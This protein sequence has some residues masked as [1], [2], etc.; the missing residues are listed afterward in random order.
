MSAE[1][2]CQVDWSILNQREDSGHLWSKHTQMIVLLKVS[3]I[4]FVILYTEGHLRDIT[5]TGHR[6]CNGNDTDTPEVET[7]KALMIMEYKLVFV[8]ACIGA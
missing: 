3:L 5:F 4:V 6:A 2:F 7:S 1:H 8:P